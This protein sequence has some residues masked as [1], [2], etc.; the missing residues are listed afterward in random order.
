MSPQY[1]R[2]LRG[3]DSV[4]DPP[5]CSSLG[6][7]LSNTKGIGHFRQPCA[8]FDHVFPATAPRCESLDAARGP[9]GSHRP[10]EGLGDMDHAHSQLRTLIPR[11]LMDTHDVFEP[12]RVFRVSNSALQ[13]E[14]HPILGEPWRLA[15]CHR[16]TEAH[17]M[18]R[19]VGVPMPF[20]TH[21]KSEPLSTLLLPERPLIHGGL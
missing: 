4:V 1:L 5:K 14:A 9:L 7:H 15:P 17:H 6:H 11:L 3:I 13:W 16:T 18:R 12:P 8:G 21:H 10:H 2:H 19:L 20:H